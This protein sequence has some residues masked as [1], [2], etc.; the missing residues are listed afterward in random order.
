MCI[1]NTVRGSVSVATFH[2][3]GHTTNLSVMPT[4]TYKQ[5]FA[6]FKATLQH[7]QGHARLVLAIISPSF[8][9]FLL[10][11]ED[12][13][14]HGLFFPSHHKLLALCFC[15]VLFNCKRCGTV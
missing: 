13:T 7:S 10:T 1:R 9:P 11:N 5:R 12:E 2:G 15:F 14:D 4:G 6:L 8:F 3:H